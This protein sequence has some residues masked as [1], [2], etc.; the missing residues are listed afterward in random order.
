MKTAVLAMALL[1]SCAGTQENAKSDVAPAST[2]TA[3]PATFRRWRGPSADDI[4]QRTELRH[5]DAA[6]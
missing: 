2:E 3:L 5:P 4:G 1:T 6:Q